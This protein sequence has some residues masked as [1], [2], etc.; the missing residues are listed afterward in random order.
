MIGVIM[1]LQH[2]ANLG[3]SVGGHL[4]VLADL[5]LR[6]DHSG[7]AVVGDQVR[8]ATEIGVEDLTE[9]HYC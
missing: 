7:L 9:I 4:H 3:A 1:R 2:V 6:I 5:P 8:G